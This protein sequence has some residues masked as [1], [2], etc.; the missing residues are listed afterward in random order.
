MKKR[1]TDASEA[2]RGAERVQALSEAAAAQA[3]AAQA[4]ARRRA[5]SSRCEQ[6][7]CEESVLMLSKESLGVLRRPVAQSIR[8]YGCRQE[9]AGG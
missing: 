1:K 4:A 8:T 9:A 3:A 7:A 5:A 6:L 2:V